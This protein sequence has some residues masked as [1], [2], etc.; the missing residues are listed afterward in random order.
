MI[1]GMLKSSPNAR[2]DMDLGSQQQMQL[3]NLFY[4]GM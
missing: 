3:H 4:D 1:L 2:L